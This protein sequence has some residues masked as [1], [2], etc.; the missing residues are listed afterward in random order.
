MDW[1]ERNPTKWEYLLIEN[2]KGLSYYLREEAERLP[3]VIILVEDEQSFF[4][5]MEMR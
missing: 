5:S 2:E 1:F 4:L 3:A